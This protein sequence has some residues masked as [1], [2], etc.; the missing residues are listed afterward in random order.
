M[1]GK[2]EGLQHGRP[3]AAIQYHPT[4][5]KQDQIGTQ[6]TVQTEDGVKLQTIGVAKYTC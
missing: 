2:G 4:V 1:L 3:I 5:S 6:T